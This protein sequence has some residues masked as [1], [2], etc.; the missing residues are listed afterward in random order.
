[1]SSGRTTIDG[2]LQCLCPTSSRIPRQGFN[3]ISRPGAR[4]LIVCR[5]LHPRQTHTQSFLTSSRT[6]PRPLRQPGNLQAQRCAYQK[7]S[8]VGQHVRD[9]DR[10]RHLDITS[11]YQEL[12]RSTLQGH[13]AHI[14]DCVKIL[15]KERGQKPN[16]RLYDALLLANTDHQYG[17]AGEVARILDEIAVEGLTPDSATYHAALTVGYCTR[18]FRYALADTIQALAVHPD[19]L[20]RQRIL[21]E[22]R[23]RWFSLTKNG[24]HDVVTGLI[25]ERQLEL[26]LDTLD[27][28]QKEGAKVDSWLYD[29]IIYTLCSAEEFDS[30]V[31]LMQ[32]RLSSGEFYISATLWYYLLDT[33]SRALHHRGTLFAYR[34]RVE[35]SYLNPSAG[36]CINIISTAARHGD[37]YLATSALRILGRRSG[38]PIQLHHYEALLETYMTAKD[39]RTSFTLLTIMTAA[40]HPPTAAST[41]PIF[42]HLCLSPSL[43]A[44]AVSI[45]EELREQDRQIPIQAINVI[46]EAYIAHH[47]LASSLSIYKALHN[48]GDS[49]T[50]DTATFNLLFRG[51]SQAARKDLAMFLASE[52]V[53]LKV[54]PDR[55]T[56]DR[57]TLVCLN[58][59]S[60]I[61]DAWR[62][63][64]EMRGLGWWPRHGTA[65]SLARR[66][67]ERGDQRVW[68]LVSE[69][70]GEGVPKWKVESLIQEYWKDGSEEPEMEINPERREGE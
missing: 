47:D 29:L 24:W 30:A 39:I 2:L 68:R 67:C 14:R 69:E 52:M 33:A 54:V 19:C 17:S 48:F 4:S 59:E 43:V 41:R 23:Q 35:S 63:F 9:Q 56:Y 49:L 60:S 27:Q 21:E 22:L 34:A 13:Y 37:I 18:G 51:C 45:L 28:M 7:P 58:S 16:L 15:V 57:L 38:N 26:A 11:A 70:G 25:R 46:M 20:L 32:H 53:A 1:M 8:F 42:T 66:A 3:E 31:N 62:Y 64:E 36:I 44:T 55:L 10:I 50:P 61:D 6:V 65:V 12:R 5:K 40:G